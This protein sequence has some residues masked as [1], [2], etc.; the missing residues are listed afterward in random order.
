MVFLHI[1]NLFSFMIYWSW[2]YL[3]F[4]YSYINFLWE[5]YILKMITFLNQFVYDKKK[6]KLW[7]SRNVYLLAILTIISI[8]FCSC[9]N[10]ENSF[11]CECAI[12]SVLF[13]DHIFVP[14]SKPH[15]VL[16]RPLHN[17]MKCLIDIF[18]NLWKYF[19]IKTILF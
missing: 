14:A 6:K 11:W 15:N 9:R 19:K 3:F 5:A 17:V 18:K 16:K 7:H 10:K 12:Q 13:K 2:K 1:M 4:L 8:I